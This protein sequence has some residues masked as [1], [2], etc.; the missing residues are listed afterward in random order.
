MLDQHTDTRAAVIDAPRDRRPPA[1]SRSAEGSTQGVRLEI[2]ALRA[3]AVSVVVVFHVWPDVLHGGYIGVDVFFA[4]SGFLIT[5]LLVR[6][7]DRDGRI[8]LPGFWARRA[9]RILPAALVT[10]LVAAIG[11]LIWVP[12]SHW[13]D[14][15]EE[16]GASTLYIENWRLAHE[17]VDYFAAT[18]PSPV[19][20]FWSLS[21]EEQFYLVWPVALTIALAV[22]GR[23]HRRAGAA[24]VMAGLTVA[25]LIY[26]IVHT[27]ADPASGY[28]VTPARAWE[29]G[30]GGLLA[31][32]P[33]FD[34]SPV[35]VR[36]ALS[37]MGLA[38]IAVSAIVY[39]PSTHFPGT[40]AL[41]PILGT[42]AV[43]RAGM[44]ETRWAPSGLFRLRGV[45]DIGNLS[46]SIYLWHWPL[47]VL[48]PYAI[49][50][51]PGPRR[52]AVLGLTLVLSA[53]SKRLIED[54]IRAAPSLVRRRP[55]ATFAVS[56]VGT[57]IV[58]AVLGYGALKNDDQLKADEQKTARVVEEHLSCFGAAA[59]DPTHPCDN[60]KLKTTV[61][62][63]PVQ[64]ARVTNSSCKIVE[65]AGRVRACAFG[66]PAS[67]A[68]KT[69]A[70]FGDS[71]ASHWRA[72]LE[73]VARERHWH[74]L[75]VTH[76]GCPFSKAVADLE[77][78][79]RSECIEWNHDAAAWLAT[80]PEVT[81]IFTSQ[82]SGA[83]FAT[84]AGA[85]PFETKVKGYVDLWSSLP[86]SVRDIVV[87]HDTPRSRGD[88]QDCVSEAI[89]NQKPA[90]PACAES[91]TWATRADPAVKAAEEVTN[92]RMHTVD[93]TNFLCDTKKCY[94]V[95]GGVLVYRDEG[96]M[97]QTFAATLGP[98]LGKEVG[99]L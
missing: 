62:P 9:R 63:T 28:F 1:R 32:L 91:R 65:R 16:I 79:Q 64:A 33:Q 87:I 70:L 2:Q 83:S 55:R 88:T 20:H 58:L 54:P 92:H 13:S 89:D 43:I 82:H 8:S 52:M 51:D 11:V 90:G 72:A 60:P 15:L 18:A 98:Y 85:D 21:V 31:L 77:E 41:L 80:H 71:H 67:Q 84:P 45:Q 66:V 25:S 29:F 36:A 40:A 42:L 48:V 93:L 56:L 49:S 4:I 17:A 37:W 6:E 26:S 35:H 81:A 38:A 69:V 57:G 7:I 39:T 44:P 22:A 76:T 96:H 74:G 95:V 73:V 53:L 30:L 12:T 94:P 10:L 75:S 50:L 68:T 86:Q 5:S 59:M 99:R 19:Q 3:I 14:M 24:I 23:R 61:V 97:T 78:P 47:I 46:Y 34:R 27:P